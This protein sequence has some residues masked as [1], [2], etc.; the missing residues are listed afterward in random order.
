MVAGAR[1]D[2]SRTIVISRP[3][4][5]SSLARS[6]RPW[7][8]FRGQVKRPVLERGLLP[9]T[10]LTAVSGLNRAFPFGLR[11]EG[12]CAFDYVCS[13]EPRERAAS[14]SR[15]NRAS[16]RLELEVKFLMLSVADFDLPPGS[17]EPL[18]GEVAAEPRRKNWLE[19]RCKAASPT[20]RFGQTR[21][22]IIRVMN[23]VAKR[24]VNRFSRG[25]ATK[26]ATIMPAMNTSKIF[27]DEAQRPGET[28]DGAWP[29]IR[30]IPARADSHSE[31]RRRR[32]PRR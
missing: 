25:T 8:F 31:R 30:N 32:T 26:T 28:G 14:T 22:F 15:D 7:I 27:G 2:L 23:A 20:R 10:D 4:R 21:R 24:G 19:I 16:A 1:C 12:E 5:A 9:R 6:R 11:P 3:R 29:P 13:P 17:V 18:A